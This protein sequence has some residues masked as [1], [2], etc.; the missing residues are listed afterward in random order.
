V[1]RLGEAMLAVQVVSCNV[2]SD[3]RIHALLRRPGNAHAW[4]W[5]LQYGQAAGF[6][7]RRSRATV[8]ANQNG[9][10]RRYF[11]HGPLKLLGYA[12]V[13]LM[14]VAVIYAAYISVTYWTGIGV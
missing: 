13:A 2:D 9:R 6:T 10:G 4:K 1:E 3:S 14:A 7:S 12:I 5:S 8:P 11:V